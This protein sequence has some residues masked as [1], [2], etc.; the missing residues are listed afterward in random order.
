M[1]KFSIPNIVRYT[2]SLILI[3]IFFSCNNRRTGG[4]DIPIEISR[5]ENKLEL[6]DTSCF[7]AQSRDILSKIFSKIDT[8]I[9]GFDSLLNNIKESPIFIQCKPKVDSVFANKEILEKQLLP[10]Y[11]NYKK[12]FNDSIPHIYTIIS[13]Y[14]QSVM[15]G[16]D[17]VV[18]ALNHYLGA[19]EPLYNYFP[20]YKRRYKES[21]RIGLDVCEALIRNNFMNQIDMQNDYHNVLS[22]MIY[23]G[24]IIKLMQILN[25]E[26]SVE[27]ILMWTPDEITFWNNNEQN[28]WQFLIANDILYSTDARFVQ[29]LNIPSPTHFYSADVA[30]DMVGRYI[31]YKIVDGYLKSTNNGDIN[32]NSLNQILNQLPQQVLITSGYNGK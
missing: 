1:I 24:I 13:P 20:A 5:I 22:S 31:G 18:I 23:E 17:Y 4:K 16:T 25:P 19:D 21:S 15:I 27:D 3:L 30:P 32:K 9:Y 7:D 29:E 2:L 10:L 28:I 14:N 11:I 8:D 26:S 6:V 12:I